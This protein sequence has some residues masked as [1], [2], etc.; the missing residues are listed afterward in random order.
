[1]LSPS[2][3]RHICKQDTKFKSESAFESYLVEVWLLPLPITALSGIR[4]ALEDENALV[5]GSYTI[6]INVWVPGPILRSAVPV[7]IDEFLHEA[8]PRNKKAKIHAAPYKPVYVLSP[9]YGLS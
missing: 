2:S 8:P 9:F 5:K 4:Q 6:S 7:A 3:I 1:M